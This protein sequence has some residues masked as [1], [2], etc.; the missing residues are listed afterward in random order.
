VA[1]D[2]LRVELAVRGD[3]D[4]A[5]TDALTTALWDQLSQGRRF[6]RVDLSG[7]S[8]LRLRGLAALVAL[9]NDFLDEQGLLTLA[10][11]SRPAER[12]LV[13]AHLDRVLF[14][15]SLAHARR[16]PGG[17]ERHVLETLKAVSATT[18]HSSQR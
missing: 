8:F 3:L 10:G 6:V 18:A 17:G 5:T 14:T 12:L 1:T 15:D 13:L 9:H 11:A 16:R 2:E 4:M 7:L